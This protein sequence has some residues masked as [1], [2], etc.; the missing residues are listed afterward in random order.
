YGLAKSLGPE[1]PVYSLQLF[2]PSVRDSVL[3]TSLE[4]IAAGY[5]GLIRRVQPQ[6]PYDLIGWCVAGAL[7]FEIARQLLAQDQ[8]VSR[9]LLI[10]SWLPNYF[11]SLPAWRR[12]VGEWTMRAQL[13]MADLRR[14][15]SSDKS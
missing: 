9:L 2:D 12:I 6:G 8:A 5:V 15:L 3:P 10:D 7:A 14:V 4:E 13:V 1:Q 11:E